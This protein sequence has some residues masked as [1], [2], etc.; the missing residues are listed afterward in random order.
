MR[1]ASAGEQL[2]AGAQSL[3]DLGSAD[4]QV[5]RRSSRRKRQEEVR[6]WI[7]VH[8]SP[9][10]I[11]GRGSHD[12]GEKLLW[13]AIIEGKPGALHLHL[14]AMA[15]EKGVIGG[16]KAEAVFEGFICRDG[17]RVFKALAITATKNFPVDHELVP[18]HL[19]PR[20]V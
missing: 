4:L 17:F 16:V 14:D 15:L 10:K 1:D 5:S 12:V 2:D 8:G 3:F 19:E 18:G 7:D 13:V 20:S 9:D 11:D 6:S